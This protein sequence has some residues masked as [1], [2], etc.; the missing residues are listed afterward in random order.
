MV[1]GDFLYLFRWSRYSHDLLLYEIRA[2]RIKG[3]TAINH[4]VPLINPL[5]DSNPSF[6]L[7]KQLKVTNLTNRNKLRRA[8]KDTCLTQ[9]Q[10]SYFLEWMIYSCD[11][12]KILS[13]TGA[14]LWDKSRLIL[15]VKPLTCLKT[16][17]NSSFKSSKL[18]QVDTLINTSNYSD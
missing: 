11:D 16:P 14:S 8:W 5:D 3:I 10:R 15:T 12:L 4:V 7:I 18:V 2:E 6:R 17:R 9:R 1:V 13:L